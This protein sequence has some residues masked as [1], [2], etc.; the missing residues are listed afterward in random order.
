MFIE[1]ICG[2]FCYVILFL[3]YHAPETVRW[4]G[5]YMCLTKDAIIFISYD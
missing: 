2:L 3:N 1:T 5:L 4:T